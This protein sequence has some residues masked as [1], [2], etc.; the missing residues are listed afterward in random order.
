[1]RE[2]S[3]DEL[4]N[5]QMNILDNVARFCDEHNIKYWIDAGTLLGAVRHGGYIPWD[6]DIDI[7]MLR[8]D[9]ERFMS[10]YSDPTGKYSLMGCEVDGKT[11]VPFL[12]VVDNDTVLYEPDENGLK[13]AV[14][15]DVFVYD[16]APDSS[17]EVKHMFELREKYRDLARAQANKSWPEGIVHKLGMLRFR[18]QKIYFRDRCYYIRKMIENS[19]SHNDEECSCIGNFMGFIKFTCNKAVLSD[20]TEIKFEGRTYKA[21]VR[22]DEWLRA[23]YGD[24][25]T[26][27]PVEKRI[28]THK[29]KAYYLD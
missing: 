3:L 6:D 20:T 7:A 23:I 13:L 22:T 27:P 11:P 21:P 25:M 14:Y 29:Y 9:Y 17:E 15:I 16:N 1:M 24:Y 8:D 4:K 5:L 12:K 18:L 10:S 26:L 19:K 2:I 28:S